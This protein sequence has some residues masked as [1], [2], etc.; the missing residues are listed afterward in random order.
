MT[1]PSPAPATPFAQQGQVLNVSGYLFTALG[2]LPALADELRASAR[3]LGLRGTV[4]L[5]SEGINLFLAGGAAE[6]DT[7]LDEVRARPG[8]GALA[9]KRSWSAQQPFRRL[10]VKVKPEIIRMDQ[11]TVVPSPAL[12]AP[13]V[14]PT[15]LKRWLDQGHDDEGRPVRLLDTRNAFEVDVGAFDGAVQWHM[16]RFTQF[17]AAYLQHRDELAGATVVS[18]CTG[19]IRCE[20]AALWMQSQ[21]SAGGP[22]RVLQLD[23]G[24]LGYFEA[25]GPAHFHGECFV[26][27]ERVALDGA[28][29]PRSDP[30]A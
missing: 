3:N 6:V 18:Y 27:D 23:G 14:S 17:P 13:A 8:L 4:L 2:A 24:I 1:T 15:Q 19:G 12:R 16:E 9:V 11:P 26:F 30:T 22:A 10:K 7:W 5:A 25:V 28:G 20:K 29:Q 21:T